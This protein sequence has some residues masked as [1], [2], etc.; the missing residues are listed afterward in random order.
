MRRTKSTGSVVK[1]RDKYYARRRASGKPDEY[2]P[3]RETQSEAEKDRLKLF[4]GKGTKKVVKRREIPTLRLWSHECLEGSYGE[5]IADSTH[6][7][8]SSIHMSV[9]CDDDLEPVTCMRLDK[10]DAEHL[11]WLL[12]RIKVRKTKK[13]DGKLVETIQDASP[14]WQ[15]RVAAYVQK[16]LTIAQARGL[17]HANPFKELDENGRKVVKLRKIVER[18]NRILKVAE[19]EYFVEPNS[20]LECM[21][22]IQLMGGLRTSELLYLEWANLDPVEGVI[23]VP[24][25][26]TEDSKKIVIATPE[27][28]EVLERQPK[29]SR[30]I[31][32]T[33][34]GKA[35]SRYNYARDF[36]AWKKKRGLPETLRPQ[37]LRGS[38]GNFILRATKDLKVTQ[39]A[40]RHGN[41]RTTAS[42]Y[43][44]VHQDDLREAVNEMA[45]SIGLAD[46]VSEGA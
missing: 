36:A 29:R 16:I 35:I 15:H 17:V 14:A 27:M 42:A 24:G 38:H 43:L 25:T 10:I 13:V 26:K 32:S 9:L 19:A 31:F 4:G 22:Y 41:L 33:D 18:D 5:S 6:G 20:R 40:L 39:R 3:A 45:K 7:T 28:V 44:R 12:S 8:N 21:I 34:S 2:G 1:I 23:Q 11:N 37:D 30:F 46:R